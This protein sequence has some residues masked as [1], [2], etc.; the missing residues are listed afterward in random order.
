[1]QVIRNI[2]NI[3]VE[4]IKALH[5]LCDRVNPL[6]NEAIYILTM[7][8]NNYQPSEKRL[9]FVEKHIQRKLAKSIHQDILMP[10]ITRITDGA[11]ISVQPEPNLEHCVN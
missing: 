8:T 11:I 4:A 5:F 2:L 1:L 3:N 7:Q 10:L 9:S 6:I